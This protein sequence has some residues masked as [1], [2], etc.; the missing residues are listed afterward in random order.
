MNKILY[1]RMKRKFK[2]EICNKCDNG[3]TFNDG[4]NRLYCDCGLGEIA[5]REECDRISREGWND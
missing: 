3:F 2:V 5:F 1:S 4:E